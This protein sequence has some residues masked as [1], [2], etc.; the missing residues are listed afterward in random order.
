M[1]RGI[2]SR[3]FCRRGHSL[4]GDNVY[5]SNRGTRC[6][7]T[8]VLD[9]ADDRYKGLSTIERESLFLRQRIRNTGRTPEEYEAL[10]VEQEG[11]C[12]ICGS[13]DSRGVL[14]SDHDHETEQRR[15]FLCQRCNQG[16][17]FILTPELLRKAA[18]YVE[19][20]RNRARRPVGDLVSEA[21]A[22]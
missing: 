6:C 21:S 17:G 13:P 4:Q 19:Y 16:I 1:K 2:H 8:C 7:R 14:H 11:L 3:L 9:R 18:D 20:W 12:A 10:Y 15:G 22:G 5:V